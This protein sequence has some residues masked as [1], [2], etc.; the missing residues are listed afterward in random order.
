MCCC[1]MYELVLHLKLMKCAVI[2]EISIRTWIVTLIIAAAVKIF[3]FFPHAIEKYYTY[4]IYPFIAKLLRIL[5]GWLPFSIG[6]ILYGIFICWI[7]YKFY[8]FVK[9]IRQHTIS[10]P[11]II[12]QIK[13]IMFACLCVYIA[14]YGLWGLNYSRIGISGQLGLKEEKYS[15]QELDTLVNQ[16][17]LKLNENAALL[18]PAMRDSFKRKS[19][20][21][22]GAVIAFKQA[23]KEFPFLNYDHPSVK[24]SLFSYLGNYLG[25]QG[26]YNPF[27]GEA[28]V[29]TTIPQSIQPF[30][31][32]HEIAHQLGYGKESEANFTGFLAC[33]LHTSVNFRYA[34]YFDMYNYSIRQL[35]I[36]DTTLA[37]KY[38]ATLHPQVKKDIKEYIAFYK[39]YQN[40]LDVFIS[41][42]YAHFLK[43]NNQPKGKESYNE[44]VTWLI[45]Y[46]KKYGKEAV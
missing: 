15:L 22:E 43:L 37:K 31:A 44:V 46:Y 13:K 25:F 38:D 10:K 14:F 6:D 18:T 5:L 34:A 7:I 33:K 32:T 23:E 11:F 2:K 4:C 26:Y 1:N 12:A 41:W 30:V 40:P 35:A 20:L 3:S 8:F 28:Q 16:L 24:P 17:Q 36:W 39:R 21:F 9:Q 42:V 27:S 45:A 29:N 19:K